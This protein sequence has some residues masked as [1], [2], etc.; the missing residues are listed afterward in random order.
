[1]IK[2]ALGARFIFVY[3]LQFFVIL[4]QYVKYEKKIFLFYLFVGVWRRCREFCANI[5]VCRQ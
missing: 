2:R 3:G 1:M 5:V 4:L